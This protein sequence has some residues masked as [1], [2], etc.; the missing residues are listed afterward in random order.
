MI[1]AS[2]QEDKVFDSVASP[3]LKK[4]KEEKISLES[5]KKTITN[6][7]DAKDKKGKIDQ[8]FDER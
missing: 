5:Q 2:H 6:Q 8:E 3:E 7:I 1:V 4:L